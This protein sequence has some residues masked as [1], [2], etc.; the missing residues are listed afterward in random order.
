MGNETGWGCSTTG[1]LEAVSTAAATGWL[2]VTG[3]WVGDATSGSDSALFGNNAATFSVVGLA[4][5]G[6]KAP[7]NFDRV[8]KSGLGSDV[9]VTSGLGLFSGLVGW[10]ISGL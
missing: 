9:V 4:L 5:L 7:S 8:E 1:A 10:T 3:A 2:T 6:V